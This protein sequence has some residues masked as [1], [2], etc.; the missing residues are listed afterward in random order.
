MEIDKETAKAYLWQIG[1]LSWKYK[2]LQKRFSDAWQR[3][4]KI[5]KKFFLTSGRRTTK[6]SWLLLTDFETCLQEPNTPIAFI[7]PVEKA[8]SE[9][10]QQIGNDLL[11]DCPPEIRPEW[12][13]QSCQYRF[14]NGSAISFA[15]SNQQSYNNLRG[16]KFKRADV[17][18]GA[19]IDNLKEL[20]E[21]V[22]IPAISDSNGL[23]RVSSTPPDTPEHPYKEYYQQAMLN[24]YGAHF[25]I[26]DAD[27]T[28]EWIETWAKEV[29]GK[30][31]DTFKREYLAQFV[32]D[33]NKLIIPEWNDKWSENTRQTDL[34][35]FYDKYFSLDIGAV[36]KTVGL[37]FWYDFG[38][39]CA[40]FEDEIIF[41]GRRWTTDNLAAELRAK[42]FGHW[43]EKAKVYRR[44]ADCDNLILLSDLTLLHKLPIIPTSKN[45]LNAMVN[46]ARMWVK[47]GRVRVNPRCKLLIQTLRDGIWNKTKDEFARTT[48]LGHMDALASFIYGIRNIDEAHNP[49]P[50]TYGFDPASQIYPTVPKPETTQRMER[51]LVFANPFLK[52]TEEL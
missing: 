34:F 46:Q 28:P 38:N 5:S 2:P 6:S 7:A 8:V 44:V 43:G 33:P 12:H 24:G 16:K 18:E 42:E 45:S 1:E 41:E 20:I 22:L 37:L 51:A 19:F 14:P 3:A 47:S 13:S 40:V 23:L 35:Q 30:D 21:G 52:Q 4:Q 15:G 49:V 27:Y 26:Y 17:D 32:I 11:A 48:A 25:T 29:G 9:Y 31:S 50:A 39:A 36:D 10:I